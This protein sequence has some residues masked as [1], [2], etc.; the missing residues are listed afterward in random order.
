MGRTVKSTKERCEQCKYCMKLTGCSN[1]GDKS[2]YGLACGYIL[3]TCKSRIFEKGKLPPNYK[4]GYCDKFEKGDRVAS[5]DDMTNHT[6]IK[7]KKKEKG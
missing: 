5:F 3:K 2:S 4:K 7:H 6:T 1:I